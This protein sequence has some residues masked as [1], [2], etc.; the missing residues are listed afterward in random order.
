MPLAITWS[1]AADEVIMYKDGIQQGAIFNGLGAWVGVPAI[2]I[3]GAASTVPTNVW[4]GNI[5][6]CA[7]WTTALS[8]DAIGYLSTL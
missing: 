5:G 8:P 7:L 2:Y 3:I 1:V 4:S 6:P